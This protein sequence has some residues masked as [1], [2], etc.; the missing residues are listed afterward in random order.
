MGKAFWA[1]SKQSI[2]LTFKKKKR[3]EKRKIIFNGCHWNFYV[4]FPKKNIT[5]GER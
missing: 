5:S 2:H 4:W 1:K 3:K